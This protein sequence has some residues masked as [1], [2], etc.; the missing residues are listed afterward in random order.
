MKTIKLNSEF[1]ALDYL[2]R[3]PASAKIE[4]PGA[5]HSDPFTPAVEAIYVIVGESANAWASSKNRWDWT[6]GELLE[7]LELSNTEEIKETE[8]GLPPLFSED[9]R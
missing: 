4:I 3:L 1:A 7:A 6:A 8:E 2:R 5:C 9:F